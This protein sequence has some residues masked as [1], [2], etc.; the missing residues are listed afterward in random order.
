MLPR[1]EVQCLL[2]SLKEF[3]A[4]HKKRPCVYGVMRYRMSAGKTFLKYLSLDKVSHLTS[5][6]FQ[7]QLVD[8]VSQYLSNLCFLGFSY[9]TIGRGYGC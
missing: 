2:A 5:F 1:F 9:S 4:A 7:P 8:V 6:S 3:T